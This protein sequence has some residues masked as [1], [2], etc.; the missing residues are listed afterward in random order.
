MKESIRSIDVSVTLRYVLN[1]LTGITRR[2]YILPLDIKI[3]VEC[4]EAI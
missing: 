4:V 3:E 1:T 2:D